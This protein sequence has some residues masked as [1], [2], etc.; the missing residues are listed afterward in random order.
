[1]IDL[2][3]LPE[4]SGCRAQSVQNWVTSD[5][6]PDRKGLPRSKIDRW[7]FPPRNHWKTTVAQTQQECGSD[8]QCEGRSKTTRGLPE[9]GDCC[10]CGSIATDSVMGL[11]WKRASF[12]RSDLWQQVPPLRRENLATIVH[13][14]ILIARASCSGENWGRA[15]TR[16]EVSP[17]Q[18]I[19]E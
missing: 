11:G 7:I 17:G 13:T 3:R 12:W 14:L 16:G 2:G 6:R 4:Y 18:F 1:M 19:G 9:D 15:Q 8:S 5:P 10:R